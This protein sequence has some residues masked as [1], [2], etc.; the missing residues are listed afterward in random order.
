MNAVDNGDGENAGHSGGEPAHDL[1]N[2]S[3]DAE[4]GAANIV[5]DELGY[6]GAGDLSEAVGQNEDGG[7]EAAG[8]QEQRD[9]L[10]EIKPG[11]GQK[12][13]GSA[14]GQYVH[15]R[16]SSK[17]DSMVYRQIYYTTKNTDYLIKNT[18]KPIKYQNWLF[19]QKRREKNVRNHEI[20]EGKCYKIPLYF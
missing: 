19:A 5:E 20:E 2:D 11:L 18:R 9:D 17:M 8:E 13:Q 4:G 1:G 16:T 14:V 3:V 6:A 10:A 7:D 12:K 15:G